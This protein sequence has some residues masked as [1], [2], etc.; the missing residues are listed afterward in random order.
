MCLLYHYSNRTA[1]FTMGLQI[2]KVYHYFNR[3]AY[4][5]RRNQVFVLYIEDL[6]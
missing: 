2:C 3:T 6:T 5:T 4:F 1:E